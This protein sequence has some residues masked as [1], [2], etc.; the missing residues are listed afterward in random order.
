MTVN[1]ACPPH[2]RTPAAVK[3]NS[4]LSQRTKPE[5]SVRKDMADCAKL[6]NVSSFSYEENLML[7]YI[8]LLMILAVLLFGSSAVLGV[9]GKVLGFL[10]SAMAFGIIVATFSLASWQIIF[11][12]AVS[13]LI[14]FGGIFIYAWILKPYERDVLKHRNPELFEHQSAAIKDWRYRL[15]ERTYGPIQSSTLWTP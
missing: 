6:A 7:L 8:I 4:A 2:R 15:C 11:I 12:A 9:L 13:V 10:A 1:A 14:P 3:A 5:V